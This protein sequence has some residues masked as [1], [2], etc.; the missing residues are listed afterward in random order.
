MPLWT[1]TLQVEKKNSHVAYVPTPH[2]S[3]THTPMT[4]HPTPQPKVA[5]ITGAT[6]G[7]GM[8]FSHQLAAQGYTL[9]AVSN[10]YDLLESMAGDFANRYGVEVL[11]ICIDLARKEAA[12]E[13]YEQCK[14]WNVKP[15]VLINNAGIFFFEQ[16][17]SLPL[18]R[19]DTMM[20][21]H[22]NTPTRLCRLFGAQMADAGRGYILNI[23]SIC[24]WM[25]NPG[26]HLYAATKEYVRMM[27]EGVRYDLM[28]YGVKVTALCPGGVDTGLYNF[29]PKLV[30]RLVRWGIF[31]T[32]DRLARRGLKAMFRGRRRVIPG[33]L[34]R[35]F[36]FLV[37]CVPTSLRLRIVSRFYNH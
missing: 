32:P 14:E 27:S 21:L 6:G 17:Q 36:I 5:L 12:E 24:A 10:Q 20:E 31:T 28:P 7:I 30:R 25:P 18:R 1:F 8:A 3:K 35:L 13:I 9:V 22:M 33:A 23:S 26:L 15:E 4:T 2:D 34:N 29:P 16:F 37:G 11:I 19:I